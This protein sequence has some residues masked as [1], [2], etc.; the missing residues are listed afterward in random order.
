MCN[1]EGKFAWL[2]ALSHPP[3][4]VLRPST[5]QSW[6]RVPD[7][8]WSPL[9]GRAEPAAAAPPLPPPPLPPPPPPPPLQHA[10]AAPDLDPAPVLAPAEPGTPGRS[11][12]GSSPVRALAFRLDTRGALAR[13]PGGWPINGHMRSLGSQG[14]AEGSLA[15]SGCD[16][17]ALDLRAMASMSTGG[18]GGPVVMLAGG[19]PVG[20]AGACAGEPAAGLAA[21]RARERDSFDSLYEEA[22]SLLKNLHFMRVKRCVTGAPLAD[23]PPDQG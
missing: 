14:S 13:G 4:L 7:A 6:L 11:T 22:N 10:A 1:P 8:G 15:S 5:C 21:A 9:T 12:E 19:P 3:G 18:H 2:L 23:E 20:H 17:D 16:T